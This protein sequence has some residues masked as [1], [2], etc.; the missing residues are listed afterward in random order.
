MPNGYALQLQ[1]TNRADSNRHDTA[2][3]LRQGGQYAKFSC[4]IC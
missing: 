2:D 3:R 4:A 1:S